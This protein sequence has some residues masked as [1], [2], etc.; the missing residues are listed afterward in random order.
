MADINAIEKKLQSY[1]KDADT[2]KTELAKQQGIRQSLM[3]RLKKE[4][5]IT[6]IEQVEKKLADLNKQKKT[7]NADIELLVN[8]I[9]KKYGEIFNDD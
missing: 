4:Y 7:I 5:G 1:K 2:L 6:S 9:D 8:K 3:D